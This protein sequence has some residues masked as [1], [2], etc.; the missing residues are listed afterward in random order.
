MHAREC[1]CMGASEGGAGKGAKDAH[2]V[3]IHACSCGSAFCVDACV[4][5]S[6]GPPPAAKLGGC[7]RLLVC[8]PLVH[9]AWPH[10]EVWPRCSFMVPT[11]GRCFH[12]VPT[13]GGCFEMVPT[14][15]R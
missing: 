3:R 1:V 5:A 6:V 10:P 8:M 15:G 13:A 11:A 12:T 4:H 14:A 2:I 7:L 9:T